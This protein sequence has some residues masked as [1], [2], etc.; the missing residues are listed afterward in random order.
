M[1]S[2]ASAFHEDLTRAGAT[3][4]SSDRSFGVVFTVVFSV[5]ALWPMLSGGRPRWWTAGVAIVMLVLA[6]A[7]PGWL[8]PLNRAWAWVGARL[9]QVVS[10]VVLGLLFAT[11]VVVAWFAGRRHRDALGL[12]FDA[13]RRSYWV[14]RD[15]PG[16]APETMRNQF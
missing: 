13:D 9:H 14:K 3:K 11:F 5:I 1:T 7:A 8:H 10:P 16:P 15:P 2:A 4:L 12:R 6:L